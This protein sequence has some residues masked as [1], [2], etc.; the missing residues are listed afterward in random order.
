[1][2]LKK[3]HN[4]KN[5]QNPLLVVRIYVI[6]ISGNQ[7]GKMETIDNLS[8]ISVV[9]SEG[10]SPSKQNI[11]KLISEDGTSQECSNCSCTMLQGLIAKS[12][13][14]AEY[15]IIKTISYPKDDVHNLILVGVGK[16]AELNDLKAQ[17]LGGDIYKYISTIKDETEFQIIGDLEDNLKLF[18]AHGMKLKSWKFTKYLTD[19]KFHKTKEL[20]VS[21]ANA[22][23]ASELLQSLDQI[24]DSVALT[25]LLVSEPANVIYPE[26]FVER[27]QTLES[28]GIRMVILTKDDIIKNNMNALM[29]VA[30]GSDKEPRVLV[31]EWHG[32][33][34]SKD[35]EIGFVGKGV[36]FDSGGLD[37]KSSNH[38]L[39]M[40]IDLSGSAVVAGV[41]QL[42]ASRKAKINAVG[43]CG[44]VENLPSGKAQKTGDIVKAMS[45]TTI[46]VLNTDAEGRMVLADCL[47]YI[48]EKYSPNTVIDL[49]TLTGAVTVALGNEYAGMFSNNDDIANKMNKAGNMTGE[50]VWRLP[51]CKTFENAISSDN[52]DIMNISKP[53]TGAGSSTAAHFLKKF[54]NDNTSWIHLDIAG[55][56]YR[57]N[58]GKLHQK[59]ATGFGVRLLNKFVEDNYC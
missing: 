51:L 45:G 36:T 33:T 25:K 40:K 14:K 7:G 8:A 28:H 24:C 34:A 50:L 10:N 48:Q 23:G 56:A 59:G 3:S 53:G 30:Q 6:L 27:V 12:G 37:L 17:E 39:D 49:A 46:E 2:G 55:T 57:S 4:T 42:L 9:L 32:N 5:I 43:I 44:L 13:F 26:S 22:S 47:T 29:A 52:A 58:E 18:I 1:M 41:M 54:I 19:P 21:V 35:F 11:I 31:L 15:G 20:T 38:M 16:K